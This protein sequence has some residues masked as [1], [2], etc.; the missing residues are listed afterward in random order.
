MRVI[1][2]G[3]AGLV[4]RAVVKRLS[5]TALTHEDLDITDASAIRRVLTKYKPELV[6]NCAVLGVDECEANPDAAQEVNVT[7]PAL[8]AEA[9]EKIG[10][11]ILHFSSNYV[12]DGREKRIYVPDDP[13]NPINVY[14]RTKLT[15]ECAVFFR[16]SRV[17][18]VR[19]SWVFGEGKDSF[20]SNVHHHLRAGERVPSV[21]DVWAS[22]TYV[23][24]LVDRVADITK[25][26]QYGLHHVVNDGVLT[27]EMFAREAAH[28]LRA[29][30]SL[31]D[32][33]TTREVHKARRPR[34][35]PMSGAVTLRD[36]RA[37]LAAYIHA[38]P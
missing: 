18:V 16:C 24:D 33:V 32:P 12:F 2:T 20:V 29:D 30:E 4:G 36:W 15:G 21:T 22:T 38:A 31:I 35:T 14:G 34:Y 9:A 19:T 25:R 5:A 11:A 10:A 13:P 7:G 8:L 37:A 28:L 1:V 23:G 6:V 26:H 3:A 27:R 17:F